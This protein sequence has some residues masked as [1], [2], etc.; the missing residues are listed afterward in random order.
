VAPLR[1]LLFVLVT[2]LLLLESFLLLLMLLFLLQ[3]QR[4]I[5]ILLLLL[6]LSH[7]V[8]NILHIYVLHEF[9]TLCIHLLVPASCVPTSCC[10]CRCRCQCRLFVSHGT[11]D[12]KVI[13]KPIAFIAVVL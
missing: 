13:V 3:Q 2:L 6:L 7:R 8:L 9:I 1:L 5:I 12:T 10:C 11:I 4:M